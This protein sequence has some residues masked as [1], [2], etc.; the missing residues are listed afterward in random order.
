MY[1]VDAFL[2]AATTPSN[3]HSQHQQQHQQHQQQLSNPNPNSSSRVAEPPSPRIA[4]GQHR[5]SLIIARARPPSVIVTDATREKEVGHM[6]VPLRSPSETFIASSTTPPTPI[7]TPTILLGSPIPTSSAD[8]I[9]APINAVLSP[10]AYSPRNGQS[11]SAVSCDE[12]ESTYSNMDSHFHS[13]GS[14]W[15][16]TELGSKRHPYGFD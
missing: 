13:S 15:S 14:S 12:S 4:T 10:R 16:S 5:E 6:P 9:K 7:P 3:H 8:N 1:Y 11:S 2:P